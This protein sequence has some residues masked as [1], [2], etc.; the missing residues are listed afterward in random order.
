MKRLNL[1]LEA[2][3]PA[4][5]REEDVLALVSSPTSEV[6]GVGGT[7]SAASG[8]AVHQPLS[9]GGIM[10]TRSMLQLMLLIDEA[11]R[12]RSEPAVI[13][14]QSVSPPEC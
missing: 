13:S 10:R 2:S 12:H 8:A 5:D 14:R 11:A 9:S 1:K 4:E 6:G 3:F 7:M